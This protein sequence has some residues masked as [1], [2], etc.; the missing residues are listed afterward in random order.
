MKFS[1]IYTFDGPRGSRWQQYLPPVEQRKRHL[2]LQTED[3]KDYDYDY[4]AD[5][6]T[7][8]EAYNLRKGVHRK[9]VALLNRKDFDEFVEYTGLFAQSIE[10]AGSLGA[11]SFGLGWA[12]AICFEN[13]SAF[14]YDDMINVMAYI[15]PLPEVNKEHFDERDWKRVRRAILNHYG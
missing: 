1:V 15:T 6:R 5:E 4:L 13:E 3:S 10:T 9:Y 2:W 11:P 7:G 14:D 12:P 8:K